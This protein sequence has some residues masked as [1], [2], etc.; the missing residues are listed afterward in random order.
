MAASCEK[1]AAGAR[2]QAIAELDGGQQVAGR[3]AICKGFA[4]KG[5]NLAFGFMTL[6][7]LRTE[8]MNHHP[9]WFN[10]YRT[11]QVTLSTHDAG[12]LTDRDVKLVMAMDRL[13]TE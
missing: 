11:A 8:K 4:F 9:K 13:A 5:C 10:V 6:V 12:G 3:A 7:A 2:A 1:L